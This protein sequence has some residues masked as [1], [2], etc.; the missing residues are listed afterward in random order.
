M[1][2]TPQPVVLGQEKQIGD[3]EKTLKVG[4][5]HFKIY[6][7][8]LTLN[9]H[10]GYFFFNCGSWEKNGGDL[11]STWDRGREHVPPVNGKR[12]LSRS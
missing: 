12:S 5:I 10:V 8:V 3:H 1:A 7:L 4:E 2:E 6:N 9:K 11:F